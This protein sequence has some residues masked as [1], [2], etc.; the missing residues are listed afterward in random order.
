MIQ[1]RSR[2]LTV[3]S[4]E[5]ELNSVQSITKGN[6]RD[7][8]IEEQSDRERER[9]KKTKRVRSEKVKKSTESFPFFSFDFCISVLFRIPF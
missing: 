6:R 9:E 5:M 7:R 8:E 2:Y 4:F 3:E 1:L